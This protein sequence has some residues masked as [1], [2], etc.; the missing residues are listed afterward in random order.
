MDSNNTVI[1]LI[2]LYVFDN[3]EMPMTEETVVAVCCQ[4]NDWI[5]Y[6]EC[7]DAL[8]Q[9]LEAGLLA[10]VQAPG[11]KALF[12][13]TPDGAQCLAH[14]YSRINLHV[15]DQI[16]E[17]VCQNRLQYRKKQ[18]Y[19]SDYYKNTDGTYTVL[20]KINDATTNIMEL[21]LVVQAEIR[22]MDL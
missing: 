10:A 9:L 15:R 22:Q 18:E 21:K 20:L 4:D 7:K 12:N 16:K 19:F 1:K 6:I 3:M 14:F 2:I 17:F 11:G 5:T 13:I 8:P